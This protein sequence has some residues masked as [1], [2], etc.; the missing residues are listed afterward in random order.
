LS[1]SEP[2]ARGIQVSVRIG[3]LCWKIVFTFAV[4]SVILPGQTQKK[5]TPPLF[6]I[7]VE[8]VFVKV[9]VTDP[10]NRYVTGLEREHF[11]VFEDKIEQNISHFHQQAAP[12]SV[13]LIFDVS[14][15]MKDNNNIRKAKNAISRFLQSGNPEDEYFLI[16]FNQKTTL[17]QSFTAQSTSIQNDVAFQKPGGRTAMY[18]AVYMGL[19]QIKGAKNEKKALIIITDGEDNSSR[20]SPGEVREFAKESDVQIY[21][22]G[23]EGKLGYG[24]TEIQNLV[25]MTGGRT[26]FPNNFNELDY[27]V[28]LVHAE[29]RTQYVLGYVPM[30][31]THDGKWRRIRVKLEAPQGLPKLVIHA[32]EGYYAPKN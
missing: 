28:D 25:S 9:S 32:K 31:K 27:Y 14:A 29:L 13:G 4:F 1:R 18:D 6:K 10:L 5:P 11:R 30:N 23:E 7:G 22:I 20:Y 15:S 24:R 8:T 17:V 12:I 21:A 2:G 3:Q 19:D 16:T 26:F